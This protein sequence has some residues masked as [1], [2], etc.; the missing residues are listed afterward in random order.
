V[1]LLRE[2]MGPERAVVVALRLSRRFCHPS[3]LAEVL[4][5][6]IDGQDGPYN[7]DRVPCEIIE[8]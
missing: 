4:M 5:R 6:R 1:G 3:L 8:G 7:V 2:R